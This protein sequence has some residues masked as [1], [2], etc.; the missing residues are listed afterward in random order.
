MKYPERPGIILRI[1]FLHC[2]IDFSSLQEDQPARRELTAGK[3]F[4]AHTM[5]SSLRS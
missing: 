3:L 1:V 4:F 5:E 2:K